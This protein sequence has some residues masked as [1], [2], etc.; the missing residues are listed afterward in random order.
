MQHVFFDLYQLL[1]ICDENDIFIVYS[2]YCCHAYMPNLQS[3]FF[4]YR[5]ALFYLSNRKKKSSK[6]EWT[7]W[8][9][10][11]VT[12]IVMSSSK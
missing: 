6:Y 5:D 4:M 12:F 10:F 1:Q 11:C 3:G 2:R 7:Y 9:L 8:T